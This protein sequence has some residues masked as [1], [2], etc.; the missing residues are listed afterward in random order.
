MRIDQLI[1]AFHQ[2]DAIGDTA[3]HMKQFFLSQG[4]QS[5]I[6]C[7]SR[8]LGLESDSRLFEEFPSPSS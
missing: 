1:P 3:Y 6:Y 4:F 5:E 8:D 7:L 2:G